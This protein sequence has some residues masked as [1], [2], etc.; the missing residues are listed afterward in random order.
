MKIKILAVAVF[1]VILG[2]C[3]DFL[4]YD[5]N[6]EYSKERIY[7][8]WD[9]AY[10]TGTH[11][12]SYLQSDF[13]SSNNTLGGASRSAACDEAEYVWPTSP[14]HTFY[15]GTWSAVKTVDDQWENYY[16]GIRAA[17]QF[18]EN[19]VGLTFPD[20]RYGSDYKLKMRK[21]DNLQW[22][23]RFLRAYYH[24]ELAKRYNNVPLVTKV[25]TVQEA[26][27]I[28][29]A[30]F[31]SIVEFVVRECDA[32][33]DH[34][35]VSYDAN[36]SDET[37]RVI[38]AAPMALKSRVLT[39]A[40]SKLHNPSRDKAKWMR[41]ALAS[42]A[43][44][45]SMK[46]FTGSESLPSFATIVSPEN[47]NSLEMILGARCPESNIPEGYNFPIGFE[48][49]NTGNC[50]TQNL[51]ECY[52]V[53]RGKTFD[54]Q[55]PFNADRDIRLT[56]YTA[57]TNGSKFCY[58]AT[59]DITEGTPN[60]YPS[61]GATQTGY[62]LK[63]FL[64]KDV[65]ITKA[66]NTKSKHTFPLFRYAEV[67]LNYAE[68]MIE[69]YESPSASDASIGLNLT[70]LNGINKVYARPGLGLGSYTAAQFTGYDD[71][72]ATL[73]KERMGE[74]AF[75]DHR[76]WDIRRW[77]IGQETTTIKRLRILKDADTGKS[78]YSVYETNTRIWD[79]K[80]YF[81][82]IPQTEIFK[83]PNLKQNPG[84]E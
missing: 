69:I 32:I 72:V 78:V 5:E 23:V 36:Y 65:S 47:H 44:I 29:Q 79:D 46:V 62:Y 52:G 38:K 76:F 19:G 26:R 75:E 25:L 12:Y 53:K 57:V 81:Y 34:L 45:D 49:G 68:A 51:A 40:A 4:S 50:P 7:A 1:G 8:T 6:S 15:D 60:G 42:K 67:F 2:S 31:D 14:I 82:P 83:N 24:F 59:V 17:N 37:G 16:A 30:P 73:R 56:S 39:Y 71:F 3:S 21:Y 74:L 10:Q 58:G 43:L 22:E 84:W 18:L 33:T 35:P 11:V 9:R 27:D 66:S 20:E 77:K 80:M 41:A 55:D 28:E 61:H 54:P 64:N 70:A 13:L 48:G 63:K